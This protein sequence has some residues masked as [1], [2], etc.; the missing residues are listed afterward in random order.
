MY[1]HKVK[2][3]GR[4]GA[5][6]AEVSPLSKPSESLPTLSLDVAKKAGDRFAWDEKVSAQLSTTE[7]PEL[8]ALLL[9]KISHMKIRRPQKWME[10]NRQEEGIYL[11]AG[12][13]DKSLI[14][15]PIEK[16]SVFQLATMCLE[17]LK[18][19]NNTND[20]SVIAIALRAF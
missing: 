2:V 12:A 1:R 6:T 10:L 15:L 8:C 13:K 16:G 9:G 7:L 11:K 5:L 18:A 4:T 20:A 19:Q 17:L 14:A 3:F